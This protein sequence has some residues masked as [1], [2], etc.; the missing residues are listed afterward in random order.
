[1]RPLS[2]PLLQHSRAGR[3]KRSAIAA[4]AM[5]RFLALPRQ[6]A[7]RSHARRR[8]NSSASLSVLYCRWR[9]RFAYVC[10]RP[11]CRGCVSSI[12]RRSM[13]RIGG[14]IAGVCPSPDAWLLWKHLVRFWLAPAGR[15]EGRRARVLISQVWRPDFE[16]VRMTMITLRWDRWMDGKVLGARRGG[17]C[18]SSRTGWEAAARTYC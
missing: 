15:G 16:M 1:M 13:S 6:P 4:A 7:R 3:R 8:W 11:S 9:G 14:W 18:S 10:A 2:G 5:L 12:R 17:V